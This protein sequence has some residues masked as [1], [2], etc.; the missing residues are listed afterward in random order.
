MHDRPTQRRLRLSEAER[1]LLRRFVRRE[2]TFAQLEGFT[3]DD[4]RRI[5]RMGHA[6][7]EQDRLEEART[8]FEGLAALNPLDAYAHQVLGAIAEREGKAALARRY[9][10]VCLSLNPANVWVRVR[11][12]E[13]RLREGDA[14]GGLE[15]LAAA[16]EADPEGETPS[17]RRARLVVAALQAAARR[18]GEAAAVGSAEPARAE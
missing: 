8:L 18:T 17:G 14:R 13:L 9:F 2:I 6:L 10:D 5:A 3:R 15:D 12:G 7:Y 4:A 11:R 1:E 16:L